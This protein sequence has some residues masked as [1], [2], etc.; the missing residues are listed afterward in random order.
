[1]S[2]A[3]K[4]LAATADWQDRDTDAEKIRIQVGDAPRETARTNMA[5]RVQR[6]ERLAIAQSQKLAER[7]DGFSSRLEKV[8]ATIERELSRSAA[9]DH[10]IGNL[11][12]ELEVY[13][14]IF[15]VEVI[16]YDAASLPP[17]APGAPTLT[18]KVTT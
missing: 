11:R 1:V 16:D 9:T 3:S 8:E 15:D 10:L 2:E 7:L 12:K 4:D 18:D 6:L 5:V 13:A 17:F 14:A